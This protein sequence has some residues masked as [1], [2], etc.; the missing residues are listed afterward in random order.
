[1]LPDGVR[2]DKATSLNLL[3]SDESGDDDPSLIL[4]NYDEDDENDNAPDPNEI[5]D[6]SPSGPQVWSLPSGKYVEDIFA[7]NVTKNSKAYRQK[8]KLTPIEKATLRYGASKIIDLS[9]HMRAWFSPT[10]RH[11]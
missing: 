11:L 6:L 7:A 10:D 4:V 5:P 8:K 1:M 2:F 9:A 3:P